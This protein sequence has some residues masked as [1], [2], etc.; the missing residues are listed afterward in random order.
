MN[1]PLSLV[2]EV[3]DIASSGVGGKNKDKPYYIHNAYVHLP[4]LRH[5]QACQLFG[6]KMLPPGK[7]NV[8]LV[9]SI[10]ERRPS[11]DLDLTAATP[12]QAAKPAA[13]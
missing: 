1:T 3:E 2:V 9:G 6:S 4:N 10:K 13:A 11:F 5:P 7:Y 12:I 8:P